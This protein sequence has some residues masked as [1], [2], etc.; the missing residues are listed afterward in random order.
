[1]LSNN[2]DSQSK[3][4]IL[5]TRSLTLK[6]SKSEIIFNF[7]CL[8]L[9]NELFENFDGFDLKELIFLDHYD[10]WIC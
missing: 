4:P 7:S 5:K 2:S 3:F 1:M 9:Q 8:V 6:I 10:Y